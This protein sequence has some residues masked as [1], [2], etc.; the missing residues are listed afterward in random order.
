MTL[1]KRRRTV[2]ATIVAALALGSAGAAGADEP[3]AAPESYQIR[4]KVHAGGSTSDARALP[5][6]VDLMHQMACRQ[7]A[8]L[9]EDGEPGRVKVEMGVWRQSGTTDATRSGVPNVNCDEKLERQSAFT[10]QARVI[11]PKQGGGTAKS[12]LLSLGGAVEL[13][14]RSANRIAP[15]VLETG[16]DASIT[17]VAAHDQKT[18]RQMIRSLA[19]RYRLD[20]GTAISVAECESGLNPRASNPPYA[21]VYQHSTRFWEKRAA[22][23]GHA[24]DSVFDAYANID[25]A[26]QMARASGW[27][28]WGCS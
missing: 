2:A 17:I 23:Y 13:A 1:T 15:S 16:R 6:T 20:P 9:L 10:A 5:G 19:L 26:L 28:A 27:G 3:T 11:Y 22:S 14:A 4:G 12:S 8:N 7:A 21:G 25:V 18:V 24:G